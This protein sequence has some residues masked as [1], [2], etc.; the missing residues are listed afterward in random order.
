MT[1]KMTN[2]EAMEQY[3][4]KLF[5]LWMRDQ[6]RTMPETNTELESVTRDY[7]IYHDA[8]LTSNSKKGFDVFR[9]GEA[10]R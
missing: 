10:A 8:L 1:Y 4:L 5:L 2:Q 3:N 7:I 9:T 6:G